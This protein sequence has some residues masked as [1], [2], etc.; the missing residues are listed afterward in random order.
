MRM[1]PFP[2]AEDGRRERHTRNFAT[3]LL[4]GAVQGMD[5]A[6]REPGGEIPGVG[7]MPCTAPQ[8]PCLLKTWCDLFFKVWGGRAN[9]AGAKRDNTCGRAQTLL[10]CRFSFTEAVPLR[11]DRHFVCGESYKLVFVRISIGGREV[12]AK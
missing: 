4:E 10:R 8:A 11:I 7:A 2:F 3:V 1:P 5:C 12:G 6:L 9:L